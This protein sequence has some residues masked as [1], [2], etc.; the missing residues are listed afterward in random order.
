MVGGGLLDSIKSALGW[1]KGKLPMVRG[2]LEHIPNQYAQTGA[3]VL[4]TMGYGKG[5]KAID[6]RL[7]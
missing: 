7:M 1:V 6:N 3:N 5:N 2:V 4:K